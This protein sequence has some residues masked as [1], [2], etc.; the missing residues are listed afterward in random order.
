M[1]QGISDILKAFSAEPADYRTYSP[2]ALAFLGDAVYT[3]VISSVLVA[4]GNRQ[5]AKLHRECSGFVCAG[6]QAKMSEAV[7]DLLT[8]EEAEVVRRGRNANPAHH[9]K[10]ATMEDYLTATG[11]EALCG[12]L[13]LRDEMD[14][15]LEIIST[16]FERLYGENK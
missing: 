14:R 3:L 8:P 6:A 7:A 5:A 13:Y 10:N 4:G 12:Y 16:G 2:L 11:L 1:A 9:A 15:L